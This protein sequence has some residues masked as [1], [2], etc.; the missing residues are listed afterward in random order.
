[1]SKIDLSSLDKDNIKIPYPEGE[2]IKTIK[3][4]ATSQYISVIPQPINDNT[5][6][7]NVNDNCIFVYNDKYE[8]KKCEV[9]NKTDDINFHPQYFEIKKIISANEKK[10]MG[11][12]SSKRGEYPYT[13]F[14]HKTTQQ[15][16]TVDN[17]GL[18]IA[19]CD[20][21]NIYQKWQVSPNEYIC[22]EL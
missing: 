22:P 7:I 3:G 2:R 8:L 20:A 13:A 5:Y 4:N 1:M 9:F 15:C 14:V 10:I 6:A 11:N 21:N 18:Y 16:L 12:Q 19:D 17:E